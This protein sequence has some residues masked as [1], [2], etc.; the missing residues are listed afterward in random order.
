V[1]RE[2]VLCK[3]YDGLEQ[4]RPRQRAVARVQQLQAAQLQGHG[5][6]QAAG[7][8]RQGLACTRSASA[9]AL[10][11]AAEHSAGLIQSQEPPWLHDSCLLKCCHPWV[12][13]ASK[14]DDLHRQM[15]TVVP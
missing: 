8:R 3:G 10:D 13:C 4:V 6:R 11:S 5:N 1:R 14:S 7:D 9:S 15:Q 2:A 12:A